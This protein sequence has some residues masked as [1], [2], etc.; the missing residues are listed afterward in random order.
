MLVMNYDPTKIKA[1]LQNEKPSDKNISVKN[2]ESKLKRLKFA[3]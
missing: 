1:V 2:L 3:A